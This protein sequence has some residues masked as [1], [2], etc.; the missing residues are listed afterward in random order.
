MKTIT[1][2]L[3]LFLFSF[4]ADA[5]VTDARCEADRDAM[6][7]AAENNR[8]SAIAELEH[9]LRRTADDEEAAR[10]NE[11]INEA[12]ETEEIFIGLAAIAYRDC[13]KFV[14]AGGT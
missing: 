6:L 14:K 8:R 2:A 5:D 9:F 3:A 13:M 11:H 4:A 12:W 7:L 1:A 10:L